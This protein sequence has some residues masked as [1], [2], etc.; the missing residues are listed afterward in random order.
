MENAEDLDIFMPMYSLLEYS[1]NNS[2]TLD[3]EIVV[4]LKHLSN[5]WRCLDLLWINC[6]ILT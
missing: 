2:I 6:E 3:V 5:F 4:P 1:D